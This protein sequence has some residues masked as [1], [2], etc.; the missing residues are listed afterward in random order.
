MEAERTA[1]T[2][3]QSA[4][5]T[6]RA[7]LDAQSR[8]QLD[9]SNQSAG[10]SG[11]ASGPSRPS[12]HIQGRWPGTPGAPSRGPG[13]PRLHSPAGSPTGS[14]YPP[15]PGTGTPRAQSYRP[16]P[17]GPGQSPGSSGPN[18]GRPHRPVGPGTRSS[19]APNPPPHPS[20]PSQPIPLLIPLHALP[21]LS[22]LGIH[23]LPAPHL[24]AAGFGSPG[25]PGAVASGSMAPRAPPPEQ[26]EAALL[27][28]VSEDRTG[29]SGHGQGQGH[30]QNAHQQVLHISVV[31][32]KLAAQQLAGLAQLMSSLQNESAPPPAPPSNPGTGMGTGEG[33]SA[34]GSGSGPRAGGPGAGGA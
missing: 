3:E 8:A 30:G 11:S 18:A 2:E 22:A 31:L 28:G 25:G 12:S 6:L 19:G 32:S 26:K 14:P 20:I 10:S 21:R 16:R 23:P 13:R 15:S 24:L 7:Q 34:S 4:L 29:A 5:R 1:L 17:P 27:L 33:A 9:A